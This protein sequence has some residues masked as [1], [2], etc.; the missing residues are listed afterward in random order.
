MRSRCSSTRTYGLDCKRRGKESWSMMVQVRLLAECAYR[1]PFEPFDLTDLFWAA[2]DEQVPGKNELGHVWVSRD[3]CCVVSP[4]KCTSPIHRSGYAIG[5][6][7]TRAQE[8]C[9]FS[10]YGSLCESCSTAH[11]SYRK[12]CS[13]IECRVAIVKETGSRA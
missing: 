8:A 13:R 3:V 6:I 7:L 12:R 2:R 4:L 10:W 11:S 5:Q 9:S 1:A